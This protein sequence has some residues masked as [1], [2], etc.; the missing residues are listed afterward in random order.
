MRQVKL[1]VAAAALL[2]APPT[3][4]E[5]PV[6]DDAIILTSI[7]TGSITV[8]GLYKQDVYDLSDRKIGQI[9]DVLIG[10]DGK[11]SSFVISASAISGIRQHDV[12]V[13]FTAVKVME[14]YG[15]Q[16]LTIETTKDDLM[17]APGF[18]YDRTTMTWILDDAS[19]ARAK[20]SEEDRNKAR[21]MIGH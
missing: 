8:M 1:M 4:A 18:R 14:K 19:L 2:I 13:S 5:S 7:P 9:A 10:K 17:K 3:F 11:I 6:D 21:T 15:I 16:Y 12:V 20:G